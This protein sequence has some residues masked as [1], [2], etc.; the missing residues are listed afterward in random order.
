[1]LRLGCCCFRRKPV[2][3][4]PLTDK[5]GATTV[6]LQLHFQTF[7]PA[8]PENP[9]ELWDV[10]YREERRSLR[11]RLVD[12]GRDSRPYAQ[13]L[14]PILEE[15]IGVVVVV[16]ST[17]DVGP[18]VQ[19]NFQRI[20]QLIPRHCAIY[21]VANFQDIHGAKSPRDICEGLGIVAPLGQDPNAAGNV[22][23]PLALRQRWT[24]QPGVANHSGFRAQTIFRFIFQG[25]LLPLLVLPV[26]DTPYGEASKPAR[27]GEQE[28]I[29]NGDET[30]MDAIADDGTFLSGSTGAPN[31]WKSSGS[32]SSIG[33]ARAISR[34]LTADT[35][36]DSHSTLDAV[37]YGDSALTARPKSMTGN[38][39][40]VGLEDDG[41]GDDIDD[42][43]PTPTS[44][45]SL[46]DNHRKR[47]AKLGLGKKQAPLLA[48]ESA[49]V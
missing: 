42:E 43:D 47:L 40:K 37:Q 31:R 14:Q 36:K 28:K 25:Q 48:A 8:V 17:V 13:R 10:R 29:V 12:V 7:V 4:I 45:L 9:T 30:E 19:A 11:V 22:A 44:S 18:V 46:S 34:S 38:M 35:E 24:C 39:E 41:E 33:I 27:S 20:V 5:A 26:D 32:S 3:V 15:C 16:D 21:I 2:A 6:A 23:P 1:M 49:Q